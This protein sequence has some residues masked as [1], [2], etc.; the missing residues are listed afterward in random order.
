M[1][2]KDRVAIVTG[3]GTGI[4]MAIAI[5]FAKE[6]ADIVIAQR[7]IELAKKAAEEIR[8]I[9]R[10]AIAIKTDISIKGDVDNLVD[11]TMKS[12]GRIDILVNNASLFPMS[13]FLEISEEELDEIFSVN[14]K[15][16]FILTQ[17]VAREMINRRRG[18]IIN[19]SSGHSIVGNPGLTHY[20]I[21]KGG[22][23]AF[24]RGLA[25][26][27]GPYGINVNA[28]VCGFTPDTEGVQSILSSIGEERAKNLLEAIVSQI[29]LKRVGVPEDFVGIALY[30]ASDESSFTTAECIVV[31]GGRVYTRMR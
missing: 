29:P 9:G 5:G 10:R 20:T 27:L 23:N 7:R 8:V 13:S 12:F 22:I 18:K 24:T 1:R 26:E 14:L 4:G 30:L 2:L 25:A 6:G 15:G 21:T 19:I 16:T 11:Q 3:G 31:D 28:I 17:R